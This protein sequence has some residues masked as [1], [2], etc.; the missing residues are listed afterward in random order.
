MVGEGS[1]AKF[2]VDNEECVFH[3]WLEDNDKLGLKLEYLNWKWVQVHLLHVDSLM[4]HIA[5][6]L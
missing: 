6:P 4:F 2:G 3:L 5:D 1:V